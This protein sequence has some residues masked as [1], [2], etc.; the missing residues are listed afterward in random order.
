MNFEKKLLEIQKWVHREVSPGRYRHILGVVT[1]S[2]RL[3][4]KYGV[5]IGKTRLAAMLH[6]G[7]KGLTQDEMKYWL[8]KDKVPLDRWEKELPN[9]WH[10]HVAAVIAFR[11][12]GVK[13]SDIL[14]AIRCHT[15]GK[16][17]MK[18]IAQV[19][20]VADFIEPNRDFPGVALARRAANRSLREGVLMK[21]R[22]TME[23]LLQE[24]K[25]VH[26]RLLETWNGFRGR[27][28]K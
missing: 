20:F 25:R 5:S 14:E 13:D 10:P 28:S 8:K 16:A 15:I 3:A 11:K 27:E 19:I 23:F 4:R 22:M 6:D 26:P 1:S 2:T 17:D 12:W 24:K 9:L 7:A 18:P 21:A